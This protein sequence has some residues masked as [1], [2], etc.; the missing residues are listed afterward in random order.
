M[1]FWVYRKT[2]VKRRHLYLL[3]IPW[4]LVLAA[5]GV[6]VMLVVLLLRPLG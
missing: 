4:E 1:S 5:L 3:G 6:A 2:P